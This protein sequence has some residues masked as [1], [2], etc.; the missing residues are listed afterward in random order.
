[1]KQFYNKTWGKK[2]WQLPFLCLLEI[3]LYM[4]VTNLLMWEQNQ[5]GQV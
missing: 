5:A 1:M 3:S 4:R 2:E